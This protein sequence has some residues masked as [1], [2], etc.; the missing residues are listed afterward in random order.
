MQLIKIPKKDLIR[1]NKYDGELYY[2]C[3]DCGEPLANIGGT[4]YICSCGLEFIPETKK[5]PWITIG[6]PFGGK[7]FIIYKKEVWVSYDKSKGKFPSPTISGNSG[8]AASGSVPM[9]A[10]GL[11]AGN[12]SSIAG[13]PVGGSGFGGTSA[14][15]I[16]STS[17]SPNMGGLTF[18]VSGDSLTEDATEKLN[19]LHNKMKK[20]FK[21]MTTVIDD[22]VLLRQIL[23]GKEDLTKENKEKLNKMWKVYKNA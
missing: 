16:A 11:P 6:N 19:K 2:G 8:V 22:F 15:G 23:D 3:P 1:N 7:D 9:P 20:R 12:M 14:V 21:N 17:I 5:V 13:W 18:I 10:G 4:I